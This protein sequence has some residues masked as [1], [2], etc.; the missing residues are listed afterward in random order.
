MKEWLK[1]L[2]ADENTPRSVLEILQRK[3]FRD[4]LL[5]ALEAKGPVEPRQLRQ[6]AM[7]VWLNLVNAEAIAEDGTLNIHL[8]NEGIQL[9]P[10]L[11]ESD[12]FVRQ[13]ILRQTERY[14]VA[15][16]NGLFERP[17]DAVLDVGAGGLALEAL[18][19]P[20]NPN[21]KMVAFEPGLLP[22]HVKKAAQVLNVDLRNEELTPAGL[23]TFD[24]VVL[25]FVLE[26]DEKEA[27]HL[28]E[29]A[30]KCLKPGGRLSIAVPNFDAKHRRLDL[31]RGLNG[32]DPGTRLSL[33][34]HLAGHELLFTA[35]KLEA[36][37][38]SALAK[39]GPT[40][41]YSIQSILPR[42]S[43]FN[44]MAARAQH[45]DLLDLHRKGHSPG[46]EDQGSVLMVRIGTI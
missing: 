39:F 8:S 20:Q 18:L 26:H 21:A 46:E 15:Q 36:L 12:F 6:M 16:E 1:Q 28:L 30:L 19:R 24:L 13:A 9:A 41:P 10:H 45:R 40:L 35:S 22:D 38:Q 11:Y 14:M 2:E 33:Q 42:D 23:G 3:H 17:W 25:H 43:A 7:G 34:D 44:T 27:A 31:E 4:Q 5:R 29:Q 32:R 37:L